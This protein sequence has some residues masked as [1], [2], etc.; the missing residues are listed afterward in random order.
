MDVGGTNYTHYQW[1]YVFKLSFFP[2][3]YWHFFVKKRP[4][5]CQ[6]V[7]SNTYR[8][9]KIACFF[10]ISIFRSVFNQRM[11][12]KR[13]SLVGAVCQVG[14]CR[15]TPDM[16]AGCEWKPSEESSVWQVS[17]ARY[18][19][20]GYRSGKIP[21]RYETDVDKLPDFHIDLILYLIIQCSGSVSISRVRKILR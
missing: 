5:V 1:F 6:P 12:R 9:L 15:V 7:L 11:H 14:Q 3:N 16:P 8:Y 17:N 20:I 18:G 19:T 2:S 10:F 21:V 4:H 13:Q